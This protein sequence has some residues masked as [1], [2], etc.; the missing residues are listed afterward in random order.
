[1]KLKTEQLPKI[2]TCLKEAESED[3]ACKLSFLLINNFVAPY[4]EF[5]SRYFA[6][7]QLQN[8]LEKLS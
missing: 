4:N 6:S 3:D 5:Y 7:E 2:A 8:N 1:M